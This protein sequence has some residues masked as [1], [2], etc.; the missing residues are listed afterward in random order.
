MALPKWRVKDIA[1]HLLDSTL[2]KLSMC[3]DGYFGEQFR[4]S[5]YPELVQF[6][7]GLNADWVQAMRRISPS[8]LIKLLNA[9]NAELQRYHET[10]DPEADAVFAVSWAGEDKSANWFDMAREYTE[11][12]HHQ[13]QIRE[14]LNR[15]G[16]MD[17]DLY[18]PVLDTFMRALP[19]AYRDVPVIA[20]SMEVKV[21]G[22]AG[23][24]WYLAG[25]SGS[26]AL[27]SEPDGTILGSIEVPEAIAWRLFTKGLSESEARSQIR[28]S[29]PRELLE[30][31][32]HVTSIIG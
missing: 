10:L 23:G 1:A 28:F 2:R 4:G 20:G 15:P 22:E 6:L 11:K 17:R 14:A 3:R 27:S 19:F 25:T 18:F 7:N 9:A 12:W 13:Q 26:W 29:G 5:S 8:V 30:P 24:V 16:I 21:S 32:L 31:M